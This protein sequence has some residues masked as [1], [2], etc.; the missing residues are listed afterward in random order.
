MDIVSLKKLQSELMQL[1]VVE[2]DQASKIIEAADVPAT[3]NA[4]GMFVDMCK[5][6]ADVLENLQTF[7]LFCKDNMRMLAK[8]RFSSNPTASDTPTVDNI[9]TNSDS[10]TVLAKAN[11]LVP[12][13]VRS[14][15]S[16]SPAKRVSKLPRKQAPR[17]QTST[18]KRPETVDDTTIFLDEESL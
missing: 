10:Q 5:L 7:L 14:G 13:W 16:R 6:P 9:L 3:K 2:Q 11:E 4:N 17:K 8:E 18:L 15:A 12:A 1:E